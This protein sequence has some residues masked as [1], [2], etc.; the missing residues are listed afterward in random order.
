MV[1][2]DPTI[3]MHIPK[4]SIVKNNIVLSVESLKTEKL[5]VRISI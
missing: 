2:I 1:N 4:Q 3:Q 5:L